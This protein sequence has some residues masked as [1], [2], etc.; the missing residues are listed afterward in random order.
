MKEMLSLR[1][2]AWLLLMTPSMGTT[3]AVND[4]FNGN[5]HGRWANPKI[6]SPSSYFQRK[7]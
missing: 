1:R 4:A 7:A 6:T 3:V 2:G 5:K